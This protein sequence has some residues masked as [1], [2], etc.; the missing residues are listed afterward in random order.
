MEDDILA[1]VRVSALRRWLGIGVL[2]IFGG[3]VIY[4]ALA[5]PPEPQWQV[6]LLLIGAGALWLAD[7]MRRATEHRLELTRTELRSSD[8]TRLAAIDEIET[9][10]RGTF[11]FKP[12]NGFVIRTRAAG[13]RTW[14]PGLWWRLGRR[15]GVGGVTAASQTKAMSEILSAVL[16]ERA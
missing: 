4:V 15:V 14:R 5:T 10:D 9:L 16:A 12:S 8:G 7:R 13:P 1:T 2:L 6:F 11:A 3:M